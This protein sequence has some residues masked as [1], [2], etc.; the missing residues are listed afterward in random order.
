MNPEVANHDVLKHEES[1]SVGRYATEEANGNSPFLVERQPLGSGELLLEVWRNRRFVAKACLYGLV[2]AAI[3]SLLIPPKYESVARIMPPQ[4]SGGLGGLAAM[5]ASAGEDKA[6][7]AGS[8]VGGLISD[9]IGAKS[10]GALYI[11]V[12]KSSSV[13]DAMIERFNLRKVYGV[14]YLKDARDELSDNSDI[15]ED[16]KSGILS[17]AVTDRSPKRAQEMAGAY[18]STLD[19]LM[20][21]LDT[22]AAHRE[23]VFLETRLAQVKQDLD[24]ASKDLSDFSSKNATLDVKEQG[25][26]MVE[27][28]AALE[29]QLIATESQLD[30]LKQIYTQN[31]VRVR[32][33]EARVDLLR[34]KLS[35]IR[36]TDSKTSEAG[37]GDGD[38]FG[39]S[40]SRLPVVGLTY[41]DLF[42]RAKIEETVFEVLTKQY[43]LAKI[44]EA[45]ELPSTK[46]LDPPMV[47]ELKTSPK[48]TLITLIG[49]FLAAIFAAAYVMARVQLRTLSSAGPLGLAG[50]EIR[51]GLREDQ[52]LLRSR[53]P[54]PVVRFASR[55]WA[56]VSRRSLKSSPTE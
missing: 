1:A 21:Q 33:L 16:R 2:F 4:R 42:R 56:R 25:K 3:V 12:L 38:D 52:A 28:V 46:V 5:L 37:A 40:I 30:G 50:L 11:G 41:Y 32:A 47:P 24:S 55:V 6:G 43:E 14:R 27:G 39:V 44:E 17:I 15:E 54:E 49:A 7:S 51:E 10:T 22:S 18:V 53:L 9:A 34:Q 8:M 13:Q 26:A 19:T 31:N 23:R 45:K 20:A 35:Q 48:R 36:G 29:G